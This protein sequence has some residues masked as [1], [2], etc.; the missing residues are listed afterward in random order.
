M[1]FTVFILVMIS[2]FM[3]AG[4]NFAARTV[5][6]NGLVIWLSNCLSAVLLTVSLFFIENPFGENGMTAQSF[7]LVTWS[8]LLHIAYYRLLGLAYNRGSV[9]VVYPIARGM[10][11]GLLPVILTLFGAEK[12]SI[13]GTVAIGI[14]FSGIVT[15]GLSVFKENKGRAV[16]IPIII[17][18][19]IICYSIVDKAGANQINPVTYLWGMNLIYGPSQ[20]YWMYKKY[21]GFFRKTIR[22][23]F[24]EVT[25]IGIADPGC[26]LIILFCYTLGAASYIVAMREF[27]IVIASALGFILLKERY[28][29]WHIIAIFLISSGMILMKLA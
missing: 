3:H 26:Y 23:H 16:N 2:A 29:K 14:I 21:K 8:G 7:W 15:I 5:S 17:G 18:F 4:W 20:A 11:V 19:I 6:G 10:A 25:L 9:S 27:S 1:N 28:S 12:L 24:K 13:L 22:K